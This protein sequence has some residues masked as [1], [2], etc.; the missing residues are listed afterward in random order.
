MKFTIKEYSDEYAQLAKFLIVSIL[1]SEFGHYNISRPDL[2]N[3]TSFYQIDKGN[4]WIALLENDLIGTI[5]LK[6]HSGV[7]YIKRMAVLKEHRGKGVAQELLSTVIKYAQQQGFTKIYLSTSQNLVAANR[8]YIKEGFEVID[9]LPKK[10]P[11][12][13][14][15]IHYMKI[16]N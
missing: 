16:L 3:I 10:I 2:N 8:F 12:Q 7:A 13:I 5:G 9:R 6:D 15:Q 1:E 11:S 14:A 4:F